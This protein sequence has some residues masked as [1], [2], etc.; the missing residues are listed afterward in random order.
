MPIYRPWLFPRP[1]SC[2]Q[3]MAGLGQLLA[4]RGRRA[5]PAGGR[6]TMAYQRDKSKVRRLDRTS[7]TDRTSGSRAWT[8]KCQTAHPIE[9]RRGRKQWI[10][11]FTSYT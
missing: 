10:T 9:R 11:T 4:G 1:I 2:D 6:H 3:W 7:V 5:G 8:S